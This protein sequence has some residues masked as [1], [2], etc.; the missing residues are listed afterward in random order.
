LNEEDYAPPF[1]AEIH[2][3]FAIASDVCDDEN[4]TIEE[5]IEALRSIER[6]FNPEP[7]EV[8]EPPVFDAIFVY[9]L[10]SDGTYAVKCVNPLEERG[11]IKSPVLIPSVFEGKAVTEISASGFR[12]FY[13]D[14]IIIPDSVRVIGDFAFSG[15]TR[16]KVVTLPRVERV[17]EEAFALCIELEEVYLPDTLTFV[18]KCAF[19]GSDNVTVNVELNKAQTLSWSPLWA[20]DCMAVNYLDI[21]E[22]LDDISIEAEFKFTLN[23]DRFSY[24]VELLTTGIALYYIKT[25][26]FPKSYNGLPVTSE[27]V[28]YRTTDMIRLETMYVYFTDKTVLS[29]L[30]NAPNLKAIYL[31][32]VSTSFGIINS[33]IH[34]TIYLPFGEERT[35]AWNSAWA[36][37]CTVVYNHVWDTEPPATGTVPL[38]TAVLRFLLKSDNTYRVSLASTTA[39]K[40]LITS[41]IIPET[42][43]GIAVTEIMSSA[44]ANC[45]ILETVVIPASVTIIGAG[46]FMFC[47]K[48]KA[49][50]LSNVKRIE[51]QAF[52][53]CEELG[54]VYLPSTLE[55]VGASAF[56][57]T[58]ATIYVPF[59]EEMTENWASNWADEWCTVIYNYQN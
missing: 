1:W 19:R 32:D 28:S 36:G 39:E 42:Y 49:V 22:S 38:E 51:Q 24:S 23:S 18:D 55:Y 35:A 26:V 21:T 20:V 9:T 52:R 54:E 40:K 57:Y 6:L 14:A 44:F 37:Q 25:L 30:R 56:A 34:A 2:A 53:L 45:P 15:C 31:P 12:D 50:D 41:V 4:A 17:G 59:D 46:A 5:L 10:K 3:A 43:Q 11:F 33:N 58:D 27:T 7:P 47:Y 29:S 8:V 13:I 16:L 48:L